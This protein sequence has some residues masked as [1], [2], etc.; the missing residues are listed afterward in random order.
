M[1]KS[2][3]FNAMTNSTSAAAANFPFCTIDPNVGIA[4]VYDQRLVELS[5]MSKSDKLIPTYLE[6]VDIAGLIAGASKGE[7]L[8]NKFLTNIKE[9]D[10]IVHVVRCFDD[11]EILHTESSIDPVRDAFTINTEL[12]LHDLNI[13]ENRYNRI[14]KNPANVDKHEATAVEKIYKALDDGDPA[15]N[16]IGDLTDE[17][18]EA[19]RMFQLLT[20]K[21]M[22]YAANV[23]DHELGSYRSSEHYQHLEKLA[24]EEGRDCIAISAQV[25]SELVALEDEDKHEYLKDL[26]VEDPS[27]IGLNLLVQS[28]YRMLD[29]QTFF[30]TGDKETRAWTI[31]K[32]STAPKAASVIHSDFEKGFIRAE[33]VNW[34]ELCNSSS[35]ANARENGVIRSEGKDYVVEEGDV[36]VFRH[37]T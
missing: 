36:I 22:I 10:A 29:L 32:G 25:E 31:K 23:S 19:T 15:I 6:F 21:N 37:N 34:K 24:K 20:M 13:V 9:T 16:V 33:C 2:S 17:E 1:G 14:K 35:W 7:G 12:M 4:N 26:G 18:L 5:E 30:T 11:E 27:S 3:L 8:G 28:V